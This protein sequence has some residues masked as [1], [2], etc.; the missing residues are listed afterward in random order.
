MNIIYLLTTRRVTSMKKVKKVLAVVMVLVLASM[1]L[2]G[3]TAN[4][5]ELIDSFIATTQIK[6]YEG[7]STIEVSFSGESNQEEL[8]EIFDNVAMYLDGLK[9]VVNEKAWSNDEATKAKTAVDYE[10]EM[11]DMK[12]NFGMWADV[13]ISNE[14]PS[15]KIIF[16]VPQMLLD[17]LL[18]D[19]Y[20]GKYIVMN[21]DNIFEETGMFM[22]FTNM[23]G[24]GE[25]ILKMAF[26]YIKSSAADL[27]MGI[28]IATKKGT[29]TTSRGESATKYEVKFDDASFKKFSEAIINDVI[30]QD[31]TLDLVRDYMKTSMSLVDFETIYQT[32][33]EEMEEEFDQEAIVEEAMAEINEGLAEISKEFPE[34]RKA[35]TQAF[36]A[37]KDLKILGEKGIT[38]TYYVNKDGYVVEQ[39][40]AVDIEL[41][42]AELEKASLGIDNMDL[43]VEELEAS[44]SLLEKDLDLEAYEEE[45][46]GKIKLG[47]NYESSIYN[48]N[49]EVSVEIPEITEKNSVDLFEEFFAGLGSIF[50]GEADI[51][52]VEPPVKDGINVLLNYSYI[53]FPDVV[54]QNIDGRVLVP[55]RTI[56]EEMGA[57]VGYEH[58]TRTV[59]IMDGEKEIILKIGEATAYIDGAEY[60]LDVPASIIDGRTMVPI[61]FVAEAMDSVVDWD[62]DTK[63]VII[64][65]F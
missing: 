45:V 42:I 48:I 58:E 4:E 20:A 22:D 9:L 59:T 6:S 61:R 5:I 33:G 34:Y 18:G 28:E 24:L 2:A 35:V 53:E 54:P 29:E 57:E 1:A 56:S 37:I 39:K 47:I 25:D 62:G 26:D 49:K 64:F 63:T 11:A 38:S 8:Q 17:S 14:N 30:L 21:Y 12:V 3:C 10:L 43:E 46:D 52:Y 51:E 13:D 60:E 27:D 44:I 40:H 36:E 65:K 7:T 50:N 19:E 32:L 23:E 31:K 41:D 15:M 16:S 55:I